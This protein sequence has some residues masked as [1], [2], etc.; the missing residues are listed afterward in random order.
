MEFLLAKQSFGAVRAQ[1][2]TRNR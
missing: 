1:H 2:P